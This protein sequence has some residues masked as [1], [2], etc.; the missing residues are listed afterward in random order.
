[1]TSWAN[2]SRSS[3][4]AIGINQY[5]NF[6]PL[7]YAQRDAQAVRDFLTNEAEFPSAQVLLFS[8]LA[9]SQGATHPD[10]DNIR[11]GIAQLCQTVQA[12]DR[13]WV[14]FSGY[15]V[16]VE[17]RDYLMPITGD[18]RQAATTGIAIDWLLSTLEKAAT[19]DILLLLDM[20]RSQ[21]EPNAGAQTARLAQRF[22]IPTI[23]SCQPGQISH[24]TL[25]LRQ[26]L[27]TA[28][29]LEGL[30][31]HDGM[32][33]DHLAQYL[34]DRLPQ[35][36][37]YHWRPLQQS[38]AIAPEAQ[39]YQPV[40]PSRLLVGAA[41]PRSLSA[42]VYGSSFD[43]PT[44]PFALPTG[45]PGAKPGAA[46]SQ[47]LV[48][49]P[50]PT[51]TSAGETAS[52]AA[53][54]RNVLIGS[55]AIGL[56]LLLGVV[57]RNWAELTK[58]SAPAPLPTEPTTANLPANRSANA[59]APSPT[60][61]ANLPQPTAAAPVA[62]AEASVRPAATSRLDQ[63]RA[64]LERSI[65]STPATQVSA[66]N[67]AI[68]Q[69]RGIPATDPQYAQ[70]QQAIDRWGQTILSVAEQRAKQSNRGSR[71]QA[72]RNYRSAIA[73]ARLVP[74]DRPALYARAQNL[75]RAWNQKI[76]RS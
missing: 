17:G 62:Q 49:V 75:I 15:G 64:R 20:S 76:R 30:R 59:S 73:A 55:G 65:A 34:G 48:P 27:F 19:Q 16:Q 46:T 3:A 71:R 13:L 37:E 11:D 40:L 41:A 61:A 68:E 67:D 6:Q 10:R 25:A 45:L 35:L 63:I 8:D 23:L 32:T 54:W 52:N 66:F 29:L 26:G 60:A 28:A 70:A 33:I 36:S 47:A 42:E 58:P 72:V 14:F 43:R 9:A 5:Q 7:H 38:L 24:E 50:N 31:H 4:I 21:T 2:P 12:G 69:A 44:L 39:K 1:M 22:G 57:W 56:L 18:A 53:F 74:R 51:P